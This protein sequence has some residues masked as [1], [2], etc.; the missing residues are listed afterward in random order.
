VF[1]QSITLWE[2]TVLARTGYKPMIAFL[3]A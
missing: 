3:F 2:A 1:F